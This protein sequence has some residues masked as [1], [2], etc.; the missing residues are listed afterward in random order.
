MSDIGN[1]FVGTKEDAADVADFFEEKCLTVL[2]VEKYEFFESE[3]G[4]LALLLYEDVDLSDVDKV[5]EVKGVSKSF[6][7]TCVAM[8]NDY[9]F[10][11]Q[12]RM[13]TDELNSLIDYYE[14]T[15]D[16][17]ESEEYSIERIATLAH[18]VASVEHDKFSV[19]Q[20]LLVQHQQ[21]LVAESSVF[22]SDALHVLK[23]IFEKECVIFVSETD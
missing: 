20:D 17:S 19:F 2:D 15:S 1:F 3:F 16:V 14:Q 23:T 5:Y 9:L 12:N 6:L 10:V 8:R 21:K 22:Y 11:F 18:R 13:I 7:Q 4:K